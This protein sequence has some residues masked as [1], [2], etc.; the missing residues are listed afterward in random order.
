[1]KKIVRSSLSIACAVMMLGG[2]STALLA[3]PDPGSAAE[4]AKTEAIKSKEATPDVSAA[5]KKEMDEKRMAKAK[6]DNEKQN[7][8]SRK[9]ETDTPSPSDDSKPKKD[10][11]QINKSESPS[12]T[13]MDQ[14]ATPSA[15][16]SSKDNKQPQN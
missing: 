8:T 13:P 7:T 16:E 14:K 10:M 12:A 1:M 5:E 9:A 15:G 11:K 2:T 3:E 4:K 6:K